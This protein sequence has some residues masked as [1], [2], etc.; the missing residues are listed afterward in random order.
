[1]KQAQKWK[2]PLLALRIPSDFKTVKSDVQIS[3]INLNCNVNSAID[4]NLF[5]KYEIPIRKVL[6]R[7]I[8]L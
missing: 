1:M 8:N 2:F 7:D 6:E 5:R 4:F 3:G